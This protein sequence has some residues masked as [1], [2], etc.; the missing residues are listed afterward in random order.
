MFGPVGSPFAEAA[1]PLAT[2]IASQTGASLH[3]L[4]NHELEDFPRNDNDVCARGRSRR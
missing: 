3:L 4:L 1:L 2:E